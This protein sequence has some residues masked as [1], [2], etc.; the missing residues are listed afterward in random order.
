MRGDENP[1]EATLATH[2]ASPIRL[3][4]LELKQ[5]RNYSYQELQLETP[6]L[7]LIGNNGEGKSNLLEAVELLGSLHSN[8]CKNDH[9]LIRQGHSSS[10]ISAIID[11]EDSIELTIQEHGGRQAKRNGKKL[12]RQHDLLNSL[13]CVGFS[14]L[15]LQLVRGEPALRRQWLDKVVIKLE[16]VYNELLNN[17]KR[18][19]KQRNQ[20]LRKDISNNN[21]NELLDIFDQQL[22]LI[23]ARIHR[24]R[25]RALKRLEPLAVYW[26]Q[27]LSKGREEL[28]LVY[29]SGISFIG[30]ESEDSCRNKLLMQLKK[31]RQNELYTYRC[32]VGPHRD[33]IDIML[34]GMFARYYG[35]AGQQRT[36]VLALKIAELELIN[37]VH[38][39]PPILILDD[40]MA[41]LDSG[42]QELLLKTMGANYQCL[43]SSTNLDIFTPDWR[44]NSQV[45]EVVSGHLKSVEQN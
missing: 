32:T 7:L 9:D 28:A 5:F 13:R 25:Y 38:K 39:D 21:R 42:R 34:N 10:T 20:L 40:V 17:Y 27:Q 30:E 4:R 12:E 8:R 16:P 29:K 36:T 18:L 2:R 6:R 11:S 26:Q 23:S 33:E 14:S 45:I 3:H 41:E 1:S 24:R 22:S 37:Q 31:Q 19:L 35:S 44:K 43:I 15:D